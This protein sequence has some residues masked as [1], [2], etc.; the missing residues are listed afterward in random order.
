MEGLGP[1]WVS[2]GASGEGLR[3]SWEG[4]RARW[5]APGAEIKMKT[6]KT[7]KIS[8]YGDAI[9]NRPLRGRCP[10]TAL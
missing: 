4:L 10:K 7:E 1:N 3:A 8:L 9:G 2:L 5:E 6:R